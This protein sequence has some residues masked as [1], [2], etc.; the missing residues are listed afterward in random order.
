MHL[1]VTQPPPVPL[2]VVHEMDRPQVGASGRV[3]AWDEGK[4]GPPSHVQEQLDGP[5]GGP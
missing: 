4:R 1:V 5:L 2:V 3:S